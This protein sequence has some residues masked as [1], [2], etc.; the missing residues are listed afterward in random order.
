MILTNVKRELQRA[1]LDTYGYAPI[2]KLINVIS[3]EEIGDQSRLSVARFSV[4]GC[5]Y[6]FFNG[7]IKKEG[8]L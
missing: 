5:V 3:Y 6:N 4:G 8:E 2:L 1:L 7:Y